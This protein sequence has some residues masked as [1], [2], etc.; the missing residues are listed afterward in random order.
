MGASRVSRFE[1]VRA[2]TRQFA[3]H[4]QR[5]AIKRILV[6]LLALVT[7]GYA[8]RSYALDPDITFIDYPMN[9]W[10]PSDG[11]PN[12]AVLAM[13]QDHD[14]YLWITWTSGLARFDGLH[15]ESFSRRQVGVVGTDLRSAYTDRRGRLWFSSIHGLLMR[16]NGR[17]VTVDHAPERS[18]VG[19][20]ES[21]DGS[22]LVATNAGMMRYVDG[23]LESYNNDNFSAHSVLSTQ[24]HIFVGGVGMLQRID[25]M[26]T[27]LIALPKSHRSAR[28]QAIQVIGD[29]IWLGTSRGLLRL[30]DGAF[31]TPRLQGD[32]AV[33]SPET[34][35]LDTTH[36]IT[37]RSD[38]HGNLWIST[39][40]RLFRL[41][42]DGVLEP[43]EDEPFA[44][45]PY[46]LSSFEDRDGNLWIGTRYRGLF[47]FSNGWARRIDDR[48]GL[49]DP[50]VWSVTADR[51][52]GILLGSNSS[53]TRVFE[54]KS[55]TLIDSQSLHGRVAFEMALN[56]KE[57]LWVGTRA[58]VVVF[59]DGRD[60]TAPAL[61]ELDQTQIFAISE[62]ADG[63]MWLGTNA[64]LYRYGDAAL[65]R[66]DTSIDADGGATSSIRAILINGNDDLLIGT[67]SGIRALKQGLWS[68]PDWARQL[69][70]ANISSFNRVRDDLIVIATRDAGIGL[71][72]EG[73]LLMLSTEQGLPSDN[74][75]HSQVAGDYLYVATGHGVWRTRLAALPDPRV[76]LPVNVR[77]ERVLS[78]GECCVSG[79]QAR[80]VADETGIW[81]TATRGVVHVDTGAVVTP[82][83][84]GAVA[85]IEGLL[86]DGVWVRNDIPI[87]LPAD[88]RDVDL[89]FT[90]IEFRDPQSLH[91]RYQL[92][93]YDPKWH[94]TAD[95][96]E[97]SYTNLPP[98]SYRFNLQVQNG[99]GVTGNTASLEFSIQPHW[100]ERTSV[101]FSMVVATIFL[102]VL[103]QLGMRRTYRQRQQVLQSLIDE[104][105]SALSIAVAHQHSVNEQLRVEVSERQAAERELLGRNNDL[106]EIN[107]VLKN[108]QSQLLQSEKM[109]SIGQLAAGMAHEINNPIGFVRSNLLSLRRYVT[110][111]L[112]LQAAYDRQLE[113]RQRE[114]IEAM[115]KRIDMP[116]L[117]EDLQSLLDESDDGVARVAKIVRD[118]RDFSQ[119]D[120]PDW[121]QADVHDCIEST[122]NLASHE[123]T[124]KVTVVKHY[125]AL[126][127]ITCMPFQLNQVL[128]NLFINAA[129]AIAEHGVISIRTAAEGES[130][131]IEISDTGCG[132]PQASIKRIF[133][134]FFTTKAVGKG[135]GLGLSV[136]YGIVHK[137]G[138]SID[139]A[140]VEGQGATFTVRLPVTPPASAQTGKCGV[141]H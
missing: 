88:N 2:C 79:G 17:F 82:A 89:R 122:L 129:N 141:A 133:E 73:K 92:Q 90:S 47:V 4:L 75:W 96:R 85:L 66:V 134:P 39:S 56:S 104:R 132:I 100:Y 123:L 31:S 28:V 105:T 36:I 8:G 7:A 52:G 3:A 5:L 69:S 23:H 22:V 64:G 45:S 131:L 97:V 44:R 112:S 127:K 77:T 16:E 49:L 106:T 55:E 72:T 48:N 13:T 1:M 42:P 108:T 115:L 50:M 91:F 30:R 98:G 35:D 95:R 20:V 70:D 38:R 87:V 128:M 34:P 121:Q 102:V 65:R 74:A 19:V 57:Q 110:D 126:P 40:A 67:A 86:T 24:R 58:G 18:I 111:L 12:Q 84:A 81:F 71:L 135:T 103:A 68:K 120:Q 53:V 113:P 54:G 125:G 32:A 29:T 101:R 11:L 93:G 63:A 114:P 6:T 21:A 61:A 62:Q 26:Q 139:V 9:H 10:M 78:R 109:A 27:E 138:G 46:I 51:K 137:H 117:C 118:L 14:G 76:G 124:H 37:L 43:I 59:D 60:I 136:S 80:A 140:S 94:A 99:L 41:K 15:F 119:M 130:V 25:V 116:F 33:F 83:E 107:I